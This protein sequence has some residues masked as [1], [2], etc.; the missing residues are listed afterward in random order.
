MQPIR[1]LLEHAGVEYEDQRYNIGPAPEYDRTEWLTDKFNLGLDFPNVI[2]T[3][4]NFLGIINSKSCIMLFSVRTLLMEMS[5]CLKH[6][7]S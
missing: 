3:V 7:P 5:S 2:F 6:L 1:L 4:V